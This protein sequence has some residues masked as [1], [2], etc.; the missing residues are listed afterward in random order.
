VT[1]APEADQHRLLEVQALDTRSAQIVHQRSVHPARAAVEQAAAR[2]IE[3]DTQLVEVRTAVGD[4]R[5]ELTKAEADVEQVRTR[6]QRDQARV[7]SGGVSVKDVQAISSELESLARRQAHLEDVELEV[8]ERLEQQEAALAAATAAQEEARLTHDTAA[9]ELD[10]V[11][12]D[13]DAEA[14]QVA[15]DRAERVEGLDEGLV[16]L[17]E[18]VRERSGGVGVAVLRGHRCEGC[19]LE[20]NSSEL[21]QITAT[22]PEQ[23][24][25]C[26]ECGRILVRGVEA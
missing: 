17:Y 7:D 12:A 23:V 5:R 21:A 3:L 25:R 18:R 4:I 22:P 1:S 26:D 15:S 11:L 8:M 6:A 10:R 14:A 2:L 13:L 24:V 9:A 19:R 16:T 20:L